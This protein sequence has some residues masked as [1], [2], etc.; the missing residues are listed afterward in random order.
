[1]NATETVLPNAWAMDAA[2]S[3][4][5]AGAAY[6]GRDAACAAL[7]MPAEAEAADYGIAVANATLW[8]ACNGMESTTYRNTRCVGK[9]A[10]LAAWYDSADGES[11]AMRAELYAEAM[12][13][14][15]PRY[16]RARAARR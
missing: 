1:M 8:A 9:A 2:W 13:I 5:D 14:A 15:W 4:S 16:T 10:A 6:E 12:A 7:E 11:L 3:A